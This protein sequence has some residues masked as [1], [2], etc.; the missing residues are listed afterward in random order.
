MSLRWCVTLLA[1]FSFVDL[2]LLIKFGLGITDLT[3]SWLKNNIS[4]SDLSTLILIF[5]LTFGIAIPGASYFIT[6]ISSILFIKIRI[7]LRDNFEVSFHQNEK[8]LDNDP[9]YIRAEEYRKWAIINSNSAAFRDYE[10]TMAEKD[11]VKFIRYISRC[12]ILISA[13]PILFSETFGIEGNSYLQAFYIFLDGS[14]WYIEY[15]VKLGI[16]CIALFLFGVGF[17]DES[18]YDNYV[19]LNNHNII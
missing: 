1:T 3:N 18:H 15:P 5:S 8:E 4:V 14:Y 2:Y 10:R 9:S 12:C 16:T 17:S 7:Y 11:E 6:T 13:F 19:Y